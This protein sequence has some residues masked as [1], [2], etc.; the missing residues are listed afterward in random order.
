M[1]TSGPPTAYLIES[2]PTL[3][4]R[5]QALLMENGIASEV[6]LSAA[7]LLAASRC[8]R[9]RCLVVEHNLSDRTGLQLQQE[10]RDR[11]ESMPLVVLTSA[12]TVPLAVTYMQNGAVSVLEKPAKP[13]EVL[14]AVRLALAEDKRCYE[15]Q[16]RME[17]LKSADKELTAQERRVMGAVVG[18]KL[19]KVIAND[20]D[21]SVRTVEKIRAR[22]LRKFRVDNATELAAKATE[23]QVLTERVAPLSTRSLLNCIDP[24]C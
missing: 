5:L 7:A 20:L 24:R 9:P 10:L 21:V 22:I 1:N 17:A 19:N 16:Q 11:G 12:A 4:E 6:F 2:D 15:L 18:G 14:E 23:L 3:A 8:L 13:T